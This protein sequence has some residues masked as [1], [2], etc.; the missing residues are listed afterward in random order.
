ML[1]PVPPT[2]P[3]AKARRGC[4]KCT[5]AGCPDLP[6]F[7][8]KDC[9]ARARCPYFHPDT[10]PA[11]LHQSDLL[12]LIMSHRLLCRQDPYIPMSGNMGRSWQ[13]LYAKWIG[14]G[15]KHALLYEIATAVPFVRLGYVVFTL[16]IDPSFWL[17]GV[18]PGGVATLVPATK[19]S[20]ALP[21]P[22]AAA[23]K[24]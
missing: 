15:N 13:G 24:K 5:P 6:C 3:E 22:V 9:R 7:D 21:K 4:G 19:P 2:A 17:V 12:D 10:A 14:K 23:K 20:R 8:G 16:P 11:F 1:P 18:A